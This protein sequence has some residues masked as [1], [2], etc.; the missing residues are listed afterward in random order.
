MSPIAGSLKDWAQIVKRDVHAIY[1]TN[2]DA[3]A[4]LASR[5]VPADLARRHVRWYAN[6]LAIGVVWINAFAIGAASI[7]LA[8]QYF[9]ARISN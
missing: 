9:V 4:R 3:H 7:A 8:Y 1:V 2:R 6:V 5:D